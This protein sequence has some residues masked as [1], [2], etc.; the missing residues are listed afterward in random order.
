[1]TLFEESIAAAAKAVAGRDW[2][3]ALGI[4]EAVAEQYPDRPE[5]FV[6]KGGALIEL[7]RSTEAEQFLADAMGRFP[8][9]RWS[10]VAYAQLRPGDLKAIGVAADVDSWPALIAVGATPANGGW[11]AFEDWWREIG[12][13]DFGN[14]VRGTAHYLRTQP[15][16]LGQLPTT[17]LQAFSFDDPALGLTYAAIKSFQVPG[18]A[19]WTV[20]AAIPASDFLGP[21]RHALFLSIAMSVIIVALAVLL[22]SWTVR[23]ALRPL[24]ALTEAARSIARGEWRDVPEV[25]RND[26]IGLLAR[27]FKLMTSSLKDT[28]D[29]LRRSEENYRSIF[30]NA[31]EGIIR[32]SRDGR[33]LAAN[34]ASARMSG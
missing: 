6:G 29:D 22:G 20:V 3:T 7:G 24:T 1:M 28:E 26:E 30:E 11:A 18:G 13:R 25:Q 19:S 32:T 34:P 2:A 33:L 27:A 23:R 4:W 10:A 9:N 31:L 21:A 16:I 8:N 14:V 5:G 15:E 12:A 17:G